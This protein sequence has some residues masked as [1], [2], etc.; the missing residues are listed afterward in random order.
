MHQENIKTQHCC[1]H[2]QSVVDNSKSFSN[3]NAN[4]LFHMEV[5]S[6]FAVVCLVIP[7]FLLS[8]ISSRFF[9][10]SFHVHT[11]TTKRYDTTDTIAV[12]I[13]TLLPHWISLGIHCV[14]VDACSSDNLN[15]S[16]CLGFS[17]IGNSQQSLIKLKCSDILI[18]MLIQQQTHMQCDTL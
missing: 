18:L 17:I 12:H 11:I 1:N 10:M 14:Y 3:D 2:W 15:S 8:S 9:C 5:F 4:R 6:C 13:D 16:N 7:C